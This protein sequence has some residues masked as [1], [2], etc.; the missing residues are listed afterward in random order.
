MITTV[1]IIQI[2][3]IIPSYILLFIFAILLTKEILIK[4]NPTFNNQFYPFLLYKVC[5]DLVIVASTLFCSRAAKMNLFGSFFQNNNILAYYYYIQVGTCYTILYTISVITSF[6]RFLAMSYP[7]LLDY[8]FSPKKIKIYMIFPFIVGLLFGIITVTMH[9]FYVYLKP[10]AGYYI[11]FK[12]SRTP[13]VVLIYTIVYIVP[14]AITSILMNVVTIYKLTKFLKKNNEKSSQDTQLVIYS[15][16]D[17]FCFILFLIYNL[18]RVINFL[19]AKSDVIEGI[20]ASAINWILDIHTFGLFYAALILSKP[21]R[22]LFLHIIYPDRGGSVMVV[23]PINTHYKST[24][25]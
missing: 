23:Q 6:N 16:L 11:V 1:E 24:R 21:L 4:K 15:V 20:A 18:T 12:D 17:F 25:I 3:Y 14:I 22:N 9:P 2:S 13:Y 10:I 19:T 7:F 8:W 5:T